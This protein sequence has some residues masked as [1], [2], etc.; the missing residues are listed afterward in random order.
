LV[1]STDEN[2]E[3]LKLEVKREYWPGEVIPERRNPIEDEEDEMK[4]R[5][6]KK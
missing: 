1:E 2:V 4:P 3:K 6:G 5:Q